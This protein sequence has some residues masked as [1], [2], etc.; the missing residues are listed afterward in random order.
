M[1]L[2][3]VGNLLHII[4]FLINVCMM[5][6]RFCLVVLISTCISVLIL[7]CMDILS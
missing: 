3:K 2:A 7:V 5:G 4:F 1:V 6:H